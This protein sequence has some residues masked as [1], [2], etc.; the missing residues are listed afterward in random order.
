M[1]VTDTYLASR[2][3]PPRHAALYEHVTAETVGVRQGE[4]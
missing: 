2:C 4:L 3:E 1:R